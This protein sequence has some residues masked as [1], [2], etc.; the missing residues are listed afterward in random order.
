MQE[1]KVAGL[2]DN[3]LSV[4]TLL[5]RYAQ[6]PLKIVSRLALPPVEL[7]FAV[8]RDQPELL[9]I[10]DKALADIQPSEISLIA[11]RWQ[12]TPQT[13][14]TT[15]SCTARSFTPSLC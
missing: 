6:Q 8:S 4:N 3:Q 10:I 9:S 11:S 5:A 12:G 14:R 15:G 13:T 1:G 7:S 2:I